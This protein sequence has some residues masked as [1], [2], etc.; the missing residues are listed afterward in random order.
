MNSES[1]LFEKL[2]KQTEEMEQIA[3]EMEKKQ[4]EIDTLVRSCDTNQK[5]TQRGKSGR[6]SPCTGYGLACFR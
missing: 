6:E 3:A 2:E 1:R 4:H 5:P